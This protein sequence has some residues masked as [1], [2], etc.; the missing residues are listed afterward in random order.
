MLNGRLV[1]GFSIL[2]VTVLAAHKGAAAE[3][4][5]GHTSDPTTSC[6]RVSPQSP[7]D[8]T[9]TAG[10]NP[11]RFSRTLL[12]IAQMR[13]CEIHFHK[14]A[15]HKIPATIPAPG[16]AAGF[17]CSSKAASSDPRQ[18]AEEEAGHAGCKGVQAG[19][20]IEVHWVYTTCNVDPAPTLDSCF[21]ANCINPQ[22]RAEAQVF[23]LVSTGQGADW[24]ASGYSQFPPQAGSGTVEYLGSTTGDAYDDQKCSPFQVVFKVRPN[25][26]PLTLASFNRW[27]D[28]N[29]F[30]E[31]HPHG[32]R[33]LVTNPALLSRI[34]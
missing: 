31:D 15:E 29:P 7:R 20:T 21:S 4:C 19:D 26:L 27:C 1:V 12:P 34:P 18:A 23:R 22:I 32:V 16:N 24:Q 14:P 13:L 10:T 11:V 33:K 28:D 5:L 25:C 9:R 30:H 17:V 6:E 2:A 3:S 8:I